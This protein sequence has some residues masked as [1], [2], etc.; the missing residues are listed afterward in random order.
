MPLLRFEFFPYKYYALLNL[1]SYLG[2]ARFDQVG[3]CTEDTERRS[4]KSPDAFEAAR[5]R[6]VALT[7]PYVSTIR[8]RYSSSITLTAAAYQPDVGRQ[9]FVPS[10]SSPDSSAFGSGSAALNMGR[11]RFSDVAFPSQKVM[12][13][14]LF[15]R[16]NTRQHRFFSELDSS[17]SPAFFDGSV[18]LVKSSEALRARHP[19]FPQGTS[20]GSPVRLIYPYRPTSMYAEP[21]AVDELTA[22]DALYFYTAGGLKGVDIGSQ[23]VDTRYMRGP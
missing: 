4:W 18:R 7:D 12:I 11:R 21:P 3:V 22:L 10:A 8:Y 13:F 9:V 17:Q 19:H 2:I 20:S 5:Q 1:R 16:H 14:D 15:A 23:G 6:G